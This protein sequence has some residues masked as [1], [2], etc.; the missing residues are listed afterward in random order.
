MSYVE[1]EQFLDRGSIRA[2]WGLSWRTF[3]GCAGG[4]VL[5]QQLGAV[6]WGASTAGVALTTL[7]GAAL[8]LTLLLKRRGVLVW[9]RLAVLAV[10]GLRMVRRHTML[11]GWHLNQPMDD[12]V[13]APAMQ[14]RVHPPEEPDAA[15][16]PVKLT[17]GVLGGALHEEG[18]R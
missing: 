11:D 12:T 18:A 9:Q 1:L 15:L 3:F 16:A 14:V 2:W 13:T 5:G 4:A 6:V 8:G 7:L 17:G 10:F